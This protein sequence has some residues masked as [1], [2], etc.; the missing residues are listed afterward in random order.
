M[1]DDPSIILT[2]L[3]AERRTIRR[4][5]L[6][7]VWLSGML[8]IGVPLAV[9]G[10]LDLVASLRE[11]WAGTAVLIAAL[12][13]LLSLVVGWVRTRRQLPDVQAM[14]VAVEQAHPAYMDSLVCSVELLRQPRE[15][16][17]ALNQ[18][19]LRQVTQRFR[20][21]D[22]RAVTR[23]QVPGPAKLS[24]L[25]LLAVGSLAVAALLP[26]GQKA[27]HHWADAISGT[28]TGLT[29]EPGSLEIARGDDLTILATISRGPNEARIEIHDDRGEVVYDMYAAKGQVHSIE[30]Y[31][32]DRDFS[33][34]VVTPTLSSARYHVRTFRR[35]ESESETITVTPPAYT[36]QPVSKHAQLV[37]VA[38]PQDSQIEI[39]LQTNMSVQAKLVPLTGEPIAFEELSDETYRA[40]FPLERT[41]EYRIVLDDL[42]GHQVSSPAT[43]L[44]EA[45][46]DSPPIVQILAPEEDATFDKVDSVSFALGAFDNYGLAAVELHLSINGD[47]FEVVTLYEAE[48]GERLTETNV[49][50]ALQ[51]E[52]QV[53]YG[54]VVYFFGAARDNHQPDG[55]VGRTDIRFLEIRPPRPELEEMESMEGGGGGEQPQLS[56]DVSDLIVAQKHLIRETFRIA[57]MSPSERRTAML[58]ELAI[59]AAD[60]HLNASR[61]YNDIKEKAGGV[62]LGKVDQLF[63]TAIEAMQQTWRLL[64]AQSAEAAL[65]F[66]QSALSKLV[67]IEIEL[68]K[69]A[70]QRQGQGQ[71]EGQQSQQP[72]G[73][74]QEQNE[75]EERQDRMAELKEKVEQL[76]DLLQRQENLNRGLEQNQAEGKLD[77]QFRPQAANQQRDILTDVYDVRN[78]LAQ[79]REAFDALQELDKATHRMTS[80]RQSIQLD[81]APEAAKQGRLAEQFLRRSLESLEETIADMSGNP[82]QMAGRLMEQL[83]QRQQALRR[84]T[85]QSA[86]GMATKPLDKLTTDQ[87]ALREDFESLM[88]ELASV[89]GAMEQ[90]DPQGA[91]RL[92]EVLQAARGENVESSMKRAENALR[93]QRAERSVDYQREAED[94]LGRLAQQLQE[95]GEQSG[96]PGREQLTR[97]L[98]QALQDLE[99]MQGLAEQNAGEEAKRAQGQQMRD[100]L[101]E[102]ARQTRDPRMQQLAG[103]AEGMN[104]DDGDFAAADVQEI[105]TITA[106]TARLLEM[107]LLEQ[108]MAQRVEF[109]RMSGREAPE[110]FRK[111]VN[112]YFKKLSESQ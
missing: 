35:P 97:M 100:N 75:N 72:Q 24:L 3:E 32:V 71:G 102:M 22:L 92:D 110:E 1:A 89:A 52:G 65:P 13:G 80:T 15:R 26:L 82:A 37:D 69:N 77:P 99:G 18:A 85:G 17:N 46:P 108:S 62:P 34:R 105:M 91:R 41:L 2:R 30:L 6:L 70:Q 40:A 59:A 31:G 83:Q 27:W 21:E 74:T 73:E 48:D 51:L 4:Q 33:Y 93:Y 60:Q 76:K 107:K 103:M 45:I 14:A 25:L 101:Q 20:N 68:Q 67:A 84:Q 9:L 106:Q 44:L 94:A 38:A 47:D 23:Q 39:V 87:Q 55:L 78:D 7:A 53:E 54:D 61:R 58:E 104:M 90:Q 88:E 111:L 63:P 19:L 112:E 49:G 79:V 5:R 16:L 50:H 64:E 29:V 11:G 95:A 109:S 10:L 86:Q 57:Q 66:E 96:G 36:D 8:V 81:R 43:Y 42:H 98:Q 56:L 12:L 28:P